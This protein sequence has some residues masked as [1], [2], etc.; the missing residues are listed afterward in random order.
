LIANTAAE[1]IECIGKC[2]NDF[3][4]RQK[5]AINAHRF[6]L[7]NF[8]NKRIIEKVNSLLPILTM[9]VFLL[10]VFFLSSA[11]VAYSYTIYP[12]LLKAIAKGRKENQLVYT[13]DELPDVA[14]FFCRLQR[15]KCY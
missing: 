8:Q 12:L 10:L 9:T 6:A 3:S 15:N 14:V 4:I 11:L 5:I 2:T 7:E 1:F 13:T